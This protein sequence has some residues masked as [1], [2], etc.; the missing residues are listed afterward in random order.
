MAPPT[1][2][3]FLSSWKLPQRSL[4]DSRNISF[5]QPLYIQSAH[6]NFS[7]DC[8]SPRGRSRVLNKWE[9]MGQK[10]SIHYFHLLLDSTSQIHFTLV[11]ILYL[12]YIRSQIKIFY[13][14]IQM[15]CPVQ[16]DYLK[17]VPFSQWKSSLW[18]CTEAKMLHF[19][20]ILFFICLCDVEDF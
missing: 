4:I 11:Q 17:E 3:Q 12:L 13:F 8:S 18:I 16:L 10:S 6:S 20:P 9:W 2:G 5:W 1:L 15:Q 14:V 7:I 19:Q